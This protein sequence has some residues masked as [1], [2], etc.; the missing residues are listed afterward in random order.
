MQTHAHTDLCDAGASEGH[1]DGHNV[2]SQLELQKLGDAVV[3]VPAPHHRFDN[4]AEIIVC[5][6]DI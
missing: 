6:N 4:A 5:Q 2:D 1:Y 3:D